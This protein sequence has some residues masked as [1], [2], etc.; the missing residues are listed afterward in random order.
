MIE[1]MLNTGFAEGMPVINKVLSK[2]PVPIPS[3]IFGIFILSD[4]TIGYHDD[5]IYAGTT[6]TFIGPTRNKKNTP[7][8][9]TD[10]T[11][12]TEATY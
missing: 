12:T 3:N 9:I 11:T 6:P 7:S 10:D 1:Q 2:Y 8:E 5:Y 4:L